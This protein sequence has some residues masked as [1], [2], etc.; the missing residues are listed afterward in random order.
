MR[1]QGARDSLEQL[2]ETNLTQAIVT[3]ESGKLMQGLHDLVP[4]IASRSTGTYGGIARPSAFSDTGNGVFAP[5]VG[6]GNYFWGAKY[7]PGVLATVEDELLTDMKKLYNTIHAN[8]AAPNLIVTTQSLFETYEEFALD[9]SQIVKGQ[10]G[11]ADLGFDVIMFKGKPMIWTANWT[12]NHMCMFNTDYIE[13]VY[14][15]GMWFEMTD[16]K[17]VPLGQD[18]IAHIVSFANMIGTQPRR[19]GRLE[20]A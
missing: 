8:Q 4:P 13:I 12:A 2:Y 3:D 11:L 16:W 14:D 18:R 7:L 5:T 6:T 17:P 20:Y 10:G 1:I 15:P 19:H 9:I